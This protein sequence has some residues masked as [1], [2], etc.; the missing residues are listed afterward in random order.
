MADDAL[1][2]DDQAQAATDDAQAQA[3]NTDASQE[4]A[5]ATDDTIDPAEVAR[6]RKEL[7][8]VRREAAANRTKLKQYEDA[9]LSD[10]QKLEQQKAAADAR[11]EQLESTVRDLQAQV[12]AGKLGV[13][14]D[15]ISDVVKLVDWEQI[16]D[17]SDPK[18]VEHA[19][20]D[21]VKERPYLSGRPGGL[22]AGT[23]AHGRVEVKP[24]LGSF[25]RREA[26]INS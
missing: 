11:A 3:A 8:S 13:R 22:D 15:A 9:T 12:A 7:A 20:R 5:G 25:I 23:G 10:Q 4:D 1:A 18:Q 19:V 24:S 21:L 17:S 26:G 16:E 2:S 14:A 6:L